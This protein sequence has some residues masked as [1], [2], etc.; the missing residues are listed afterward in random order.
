MPLVIV[1]RP[2]VRS[3]VRDPSGPERAYRSRPRFLER[4]HSRTPRR[5]SAF[6]LSQVTV[7]PRGMG[8]RS[9]STKYVSA[10]AIWRSSRGNNLAPCSTTNAPPRQSR[11][12]MNVDQVPTRTAIVGRR[13]LHGREQLDVGDGNLRIPRGQDLDLRRDLLVHDEAGFQRA[14]ERAYRLPSVL[15]DSRGLLR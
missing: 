3:S 11:D 12:G 5:S 10:R 1:R 2:P 8:C 13:C 4:S 15:P 14:V 7:Q 6:T 9:A